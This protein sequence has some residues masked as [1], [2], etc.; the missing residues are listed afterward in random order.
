MPETIASLPFPDQTTLSD[1][2]RT[3][4]K[5]IASGNGGLKSLLREAGLPYKRS[6]EQMNRTQGVRVDLLPALAAAG[7]HE[8]I[9]IV[10]D[11]CGFT[12]TPKATFLRKPNGGRPLRAH[13]LS[14]HHAVAALTMTLEAALEDGA[15]S[16]AER[17][18]L[19]NDLHKVRCVLAEMEA[20]IE[21]GRK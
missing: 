10:A 1:T 16:K 3:A 19:K 2:V 11:A 4:V 6:W 21:G 5:R 7:V 13:G 17:R 15:I 9:C 12:V 20:R 8:P 14:I 18:G